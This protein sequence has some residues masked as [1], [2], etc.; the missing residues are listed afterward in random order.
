MM[1]DDIRARLYRQR[2][3]QASA[4]DDWTAPLHCSGREDNR[5][6]GPMRHGRLAPAMIRFSAV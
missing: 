5:G 6:Q 1:A 4:V 2:L 3:P